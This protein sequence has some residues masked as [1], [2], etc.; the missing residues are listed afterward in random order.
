MDK[1]AER[2]TQSL[3][4]ARHTGRDDS[5]GHNETFVTASHVRGGTLR[6]TFRTTLWSYDSLAKGGLQYSHRRGR[7]AN[8]ASYHN[9]KSRSGTAAPECTVCY[10]GPDDT[11]TAVPVF[12][13]RDNLCFHTL[14]TIEAMF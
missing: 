1:L 13:N 8:A 14:N 12:L 6:R 11:G 5:A 4:P 9:K 7:V 3:D 2:S 10:D